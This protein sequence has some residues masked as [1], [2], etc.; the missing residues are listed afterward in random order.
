[1]SKTITVT[2]KEEKALERAEEFLQGLH[3]RD[4]PEDAAEG[5]KDSLA[6]IKRVNKKL[7]GNSHMGGSILPSSGPTTYEDKV[8]KFGTFQTRP[9]V[10][11]DTHG[12]FYARNAGDYAGKFILLA[13]HPNGYTCDALAKRI[14]NA[15]GDSEGKSAE[16]KDALDQ[17]Q[18]ILDCG[19]LAR[20]MG[21]FEQVIKGDW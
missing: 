17:V 7:S 1:M 13:T 2:E 4:E 6:G 11:L 10:D 19:G 5:L 15:W 3:N 21:T 8:G 18:Y 12:L 20:H 14:I 16:E 9:I